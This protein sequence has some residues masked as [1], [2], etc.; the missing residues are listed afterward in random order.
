MSRKKKRILILLFVLAAALVIYVGASLWISYN[1]LTVEDYT[2]TLGQEG[3]EL[4]VVVIGDLHD[5]EF[6][7]E[8]QE[9]A[10]KISEIE[11]DLILMDG[12]MLNSDSESARVP[13]TLIEKL[14]DVAPIYYALG[15]HEEDYIARGN[16]NLIQELT[17]AG[18]VVLD[19]E[20][21]DLEAGG[22]EIRLGGLYAY[23]F[24]TDPKSGYN[25]ADD[26]PADVREFLEEFQDTDRVKIMM[27]HR[28]DSFVFGDTSQ[29]WDVDLVV[30]AHDHGGQVVVPFLGGLY[31]GDQGWF[32]DYVHGLYQK[33][34]I[35]LFVTSGL[36]TNKKALPRFNNPP[37]IAVL[38]ITV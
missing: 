11:P 17:D 6:G 19:Q 15:N 4:K 30:S 24:G 31:G 14:K 7:E 34:K 5:H 1:L 25:E 22:V 18:A 29:V 21:A 2:V 36:G 20:Y 12:D 32:P 38:H 26:A 16:E 23:A 28:P 13:V 9:L 33:D 35:Q 3:K 27:S 37:E 8:N 10:E